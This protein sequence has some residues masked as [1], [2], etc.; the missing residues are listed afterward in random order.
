[1]A[2]ERPLWPPKLSTLNQKQLSSWGEVHTLDFR[3]LRKRAV[4]KGGKNKR[5]LNVIATF[6]VVIIPTNTL[7]SVTYMTRHTISI[8]SRHKQADVQE[9]QPV[10]ARL[11]EI[12][13]IGRDPERPRS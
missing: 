2:F 13:Q 10:I 4:R 12:L 5:R 8:H 7:Q 6:F 11:E 9:R 1:M 3:R